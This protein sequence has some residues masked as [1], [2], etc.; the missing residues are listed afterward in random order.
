VTTAVEIVNALLEDRL[1][2]AT[3]PAR[4]DA[5][6]VFGPDIPE[7]GYFFNGPDGF[8]EFIQA[9][10]GE[11]ALLRT[12]ADRKK[13]INFFVDYG[14]TLIF[15]RQGRLQIFSKLKLRFS[16]EAVN[17][18]EKTLGLD[19]TTPVEFNGKVE[20]ASKVI[21]GAPGAQ[22]TNQQGKPNAPQQK[23][24]QIAQ[25]KGMML[26]GSFGG[27]YGPR[28]L[29]EPGNKVNMGA[30]QKGVRAGYAYVIKYP[31]GGLNVVKPAGGYKFSVDEIDEME[32]E[33]GIN[34]QTPVQLFT[35]T[36]APAAATKTTA[37]VAIYGRAPAAQPR[38][39]GL[40]TPPPTIP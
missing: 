3:T 30:L 4:R 37:A 1:E 20:P 13:Y 11:A 36:I 10:R 15:Q 35:G 40:A 38:Q 28:G 25:Q 5:F 32:K 18:M 19:E 9:K 23:P 29:L 14:Y 34:Q 16:P 39:P 31:N 17:M 33:M 6:V 8:G 12:A 27:L 22:G 21:F 7:R 26:K 2:E 24:S